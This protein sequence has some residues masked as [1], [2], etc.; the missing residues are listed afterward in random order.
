[1][2]MARNDC[3]SEVRVV[4][5][6]LDLWKEDSQKQFSNII[7]SHSNSLT[8]GVNDLVIKVSNLQNDLLSIKMERNVLLQT[9]DKLNGEIRELNTML[10]MAPPSPEHEENIT[11]DTQ[12]DNSEVRVPNMLEELDGPGV[13]IEIDTEDISIDNGDK[14][15]TDIQN[16]NECP[17]NYPY[18]INDT[19]L[20]GLNHENIIED[21]QKHKD[22]NEDTSD[23]SVEKKMEH[24]KMKKVHAV[25]I[26]CK[27]S[28]STNESLQIHLENVHSN[29]DESE[30]KDK[31]LE[32]KSKTV[33]EKDSPQQGISSDHRLPYQKCMMKEKQKCQQCPYETSYYGRMKIHVNDVHEKVRNHICQECGY[34]TSQKSNLGY[35]LASVHNMSK[36][37][38]ECEQC[39]YKAHAKAHLNRHIEYTHKTNKMQFKCELCPFITTFK[40]TFKRHVEGVHLYK[41]GHD[42]R[43]DK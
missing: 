28:F 11:Q 34:A 32:K 27:V 2:T 19:P 33:E 37:R 39:T 10:T 29:F 15:D 17:L 31:E 1:M 8:K 43:E 3:Q 16:L 12:E 13:Q 22:L 9:V 30:I 25:C 23:I 40:S 24:R 18:H 35:H 36:K 21:I 26:E 20:N 42:L 7:D 14:A 41:I 38:F 5:E 6:K 4:F